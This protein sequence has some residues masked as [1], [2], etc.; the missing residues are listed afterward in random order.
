MLGNFNAN[1]INQY[2]QIPIMAIDFGSKVVGTAKFTPNIDPF[3]LMLQKII[4]KNEA[5]V[6]KEIASL[7]SQESIEVIVV[8]IPY[9]TDGKESEQTLKNKKFKELIQNSFLD[10]QVFEQDETLTTKE[11]EER[12]QNSPQ[13]NFKIDPTQI[14]CM[15]AVIILEDFLK[16]N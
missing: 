5:Q 4:V 15:S 3:P 6:I 14:D 12:M 1:K 8:G 11:A 2:D 7:I 9:F 13:F 16:S 10:L